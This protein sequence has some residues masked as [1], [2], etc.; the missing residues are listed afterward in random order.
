MW[1]NAEP[2][3]R[4]QF[5][6]LWRRKADNEAFRAALDHDLSKHPEWD[7]VLHPEKYEPPASATLN[8]P[9]TPPAP[10]ATAA[11]IP[12]NP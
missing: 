9:S 10:P 1:L 6:V 8:T 12:K 2:T 4:R 7:P 5:V 3:V 11:P